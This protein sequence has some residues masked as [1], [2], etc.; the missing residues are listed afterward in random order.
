MDYTYNGTKL[1]YALKIDSKGSITFT[2]NSSKKVTV[3]AKGKSSGTKILVGSNTA[4][5]TTSVTAYS[6]NLSKGTYTIKRSSGESYIFVV[7][8]E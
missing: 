7:V 8:I 4:T 5:L 3:Y 2:L 6:Y 1:D